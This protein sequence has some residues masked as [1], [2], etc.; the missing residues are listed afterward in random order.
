M[1][2]VVLLNKAGLKPFAEIHGAWLLVPVIVLASSVYIV[3]VE[4]HFLGQVQS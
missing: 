1:F 2:K 3:S 4:V